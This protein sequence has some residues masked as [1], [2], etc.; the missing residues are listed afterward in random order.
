MNLNKNVNII[1][2]K[3]INLNKNILKTKLYSYQIINSVSIQINY[4]QNQL[5]ITNISNKIIIINI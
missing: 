1:H 3:N 2:L 5:I 4:Y